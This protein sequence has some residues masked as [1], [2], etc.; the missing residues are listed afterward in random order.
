MRQES[1]IR[2]FLLSNFVTNVGNGLQILGAGFVAFESTNSIYSIAAVFIIYSIPQLFASYFVGSV[3]SKTGPK[4][5]ALITNY[6]R[7][8]LLAVLGVAVFVD[9]EVLI[10]TYVLTFA[11]SFL[12]AFYQP[13]ANSL[14][15][16][17][18]ADR[19]DLYKSKSSQLELLT[20]IA[21]LVSVTLGAVL[22]DLMGIHVVFLLNAATFL[23]AGLFVQ[24]IKVGRTPADAPDR[25]N[26]ISAYFATI[27]DHPDLVLNFALGKIIPSVM[28][29]LIIFFVIGDLGA[30]F[31]ALGLVDAVAILGIGLGVWIV[32]FVSD[33]HNNSAMS[34]CM[35]GSATFL[36]LVG[37]AGF[38]VLVGAFF[39]STCLFGLSRVIARI[40]IMETVTD[41]EVPA[42]YT[43]KLRW[44][45]S[46]DDYDDCYI[47][48]CGFHWNRVRLHFPR[49]ILRI[50][51]PFCIE[52][53]GLD[54]VYK[55]SSCIFEQ[56]LKTTG[57]TMDTKEA[58]LTA[59]L[60]KTC[61]IQRDS[62]IRW[63]HDTV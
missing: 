10:L 39:V 52:I 53:R 62:T 38:N 58:N 46:C 37:I 33:E 7:A 21:M 15:Q 27:Q 25:R 6:V 44:H 61:L 31:S 54:Q 29:T 8:A 59:S 19:P 56:R 20:Q 55:R 43:R 4:D 9:F 32:R 26:P 14:F 40:N 63:M 1:D 23:V 12:D 11:T 22:V 48:C 5:I 24:S 60:F 45:C 35:Y 49:H 50:S 30:S 47:G 18:L 41:S 36:G 17:T 3:L 28:N 51:H 2:K 34:L 13:A 42:L 16:R 57:L